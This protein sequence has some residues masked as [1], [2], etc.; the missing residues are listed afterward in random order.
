[1]EYISKRQII[2]P[3]AGLAG[4]PTPTPVI[5]FTQIAAKLSDTMWKD[6]YGK[7]SRK[8]RNMLEGMFTKTKAKKKGGMVSLKSK[9]RD[10]AHLEVRQGLIE[11]ENEQLCEEVFKTWFMAH[12]SLLEDSLDFF[13]ISHKNGITDEELTPIEEATPEKLSEYISLMQG[14]G[15]GVEALSLYLAFVQAK[16]ILKSEAVLKTFQTWQAESSAP[17]PDPDPF[18]ENAAAETSAE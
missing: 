8:V 3:M 15:H 18:D 16:G 2:D 11:E 7:S 10:K 14:K 13:G 9:S 17:Q 1:M 12:Q 5:S 6:V 4:Q